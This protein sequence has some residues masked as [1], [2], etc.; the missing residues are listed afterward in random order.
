ML[1]QRNGLSRRHV[2]A[3]PVHPRGLPQ[4]QSSL[5]GRIHIEA[6]PGSANS[7]VH[8]VDVPC[9][10]FRPLRSWRRLGADMVMLYPMNR[11]SNFDGHIETLRRFKEVASG[12]TQCHELGAL[13]LL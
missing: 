3:R 12:Q 8:P 9:T 10:Y 13:Y 5:D 1:R 4:C 7:V 11:I 2:H 6:G